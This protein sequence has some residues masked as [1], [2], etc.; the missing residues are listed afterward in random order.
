MPTPQVL[1]STSSV[2]P[3]AST[4]AFE[5]SASLGFDGIELMIGVDSLSIDI[6][7]V[8]KLADYH[9]VRVQSVHAPTLLVT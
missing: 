3:E 9:G 6:D 5:L 1:L 7:A 2:Y 4:S 8:A